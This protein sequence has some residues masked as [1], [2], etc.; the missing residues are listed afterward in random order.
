[1]KCESDTS[2]RK[3]YERLWLEARAMRGFLAGTSMK[4]TLRTLILHCT[5]VLM[6][7]THVRWSQL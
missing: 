6:Y 2:A 7:S 5:H 4:I 3:V 1:M